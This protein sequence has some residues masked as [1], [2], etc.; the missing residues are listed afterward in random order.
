MGVERPTAGAADHVIA[1]T[2]LA[3]GDL[4]GALARAL[5][6]PS[7]EIVYWLPERKTFADLDGRPVRPPSA[8]GEITATMILDSTS[9]PIAVLLHDVALLHEAEHVQAVCSAAGLALESARQQ[10]ELRARLAEVTGSRTRIVES[11]HEL[12]ERDYGVKRVTLEAQ[13]PADT[14]AGLLRQAP[15]SEN[16]RIAGADD[17]VSQLDTLSPG[18]ERLAAVIGAA[19]VAVLEVNL[20][21]RVVRWNTAAERIFG[22]REEDVLG[23]PVPFVPADR[24]TEFQWLLERVRAGHAYTGF[25]TVRQ[26]RD[27]THVAVEIAAAPVRDESGAITSHMVVVTDVSERMRHERE[28]RESRAKIVEVGDAER[29]R[30]ERNL[31]DGAQQRLVALSLELSLLKQRFEGD[32]EAREAID[33]ARRELSESLQELRELARGIH[34]AIV[35]AH[36]LAVAVESL[37]GRSPVPVT[38]MVDLDDRASEACQVA[39]YY[40]VSESLTNVAKY[41]HASTATIEIRSSDTY[42]FVEVRDDGR[43]GADATAGSGLRG[44]ADRMEAVGGRLQ[45][46]SPTGGGTRIRAELP[47]AP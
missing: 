39:A 25:E 36:G 22:W 34:P 43:G 23:E 11:A 24:E 7:L 27:G 37:A 41:A 16:A 18:E 5:R 12:R 33:E 46:W 45:V 4:G 2:P 3:A 44:L 29:R 20:D 32:A 21:T 10:V 28:L 19:P 17:L 14:I 6:D 38:L 47:I 26:R 8:H 15:L 42:L 40:V 13:G 35:T 30:L 1:L 31:H 9:E